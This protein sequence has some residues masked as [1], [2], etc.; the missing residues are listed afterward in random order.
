MER[1]SIRT[2]VFADEGTPEQK[3]EKVYESS[4]VRIFS[5]IKQKRMY[6]LFHEKHSSFIQHISGAY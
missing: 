3:K 6:Q 5:D 2:S 1:R 4:M